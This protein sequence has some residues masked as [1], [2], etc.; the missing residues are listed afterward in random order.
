MLEPKRF[1]SDLV[2][3]QVGFFAGVPDSLLKDPCQ[4]FAHELP[5]SQHVI[6]ANEGNAVGLAIGYHLA[7]GNVPLVYLQNSGLGN[8]INPLLSLADPDCYGI[9]LLLLIGWRGEPGVKDEPQHMKQGKTTLELLQAMGIPHSTLDSSA[10]DAST[11]IGKAVA[12]AKDARS[13][14]ALVVRK[15]TFSKFEAKSPTPADG[16]PLTREQAIKIVIASLGRRDIVVSTTG[17]AS[18]EVFEMREIE[19]HGHEKDFLTIGG[20]GHASQIALGIALQKPDRQ[21][22]C[23]DGDGAAL[24]HLGSMAISGT[25]GC[26]NFKHIVLNNGAHDSV[27]GQPT[28][29]NRINLTLVATAL[30]YK[31]ARSAATPDHVRSNI[32]DLL[33]TGGPGFLEIVVAK[34]SRADLGRP[35]R[36]PAQNK[37]DFMEYVRS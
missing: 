25:S 24:M 36:S 13:P 7:T 27:G 21:V 6:A 28:V 9:P 2:S 8:V 19:G 32:E 5:R 10:E 12:T 17:M 18:R 23:L 16:P 29:A 34:G 35:T 31:F 37:D 22:V 3:H 4:C 15:G 26:L 33:N 1:L 11:I 30:N 20:M 14:Y